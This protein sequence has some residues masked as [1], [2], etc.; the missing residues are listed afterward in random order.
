M[1][2]FLLDTNVVSELAKRAPDPQVVAFLNSRDDLW[3]STV[4]TYELEFGLRLLP[5]GRRRRQLEDALT[6]IVTEHQHRLLPVGRREA[7]QGARLRAQ[8]QLAGRIASVSD[9]LIAGTAAA[10]DLAIATRNVSDFEGLGVDV[11]S[12][13]TVL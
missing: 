2:G 5:V 9:S 3:L 12:P 10:H 6:A 11:V 4:V 13:W 8:A 7:R 1:R